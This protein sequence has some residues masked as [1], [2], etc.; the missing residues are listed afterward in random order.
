MNEPQPFPAPSGLAP[1]QGLSIASLILGILSYVFCLFFITGIPA[2]ITG[3]IAHSRARKQPQLYGGAGLALAGLILGYLSLPFSLVGASLLLPALAKAKAR[4]QT[5]Q[6][7]GNMKMI[8]LGARLYSNDHN[9]RFPPDFL[10]M[11]NELVT[12]KIL[13]CPADSSKTRAADFSQFNPSQNLS[14]EFLTPSAKEAD[15]LN[16]VAF[17]CP[18]HGNVGMG[19]GSVQQRGGGNVRR[20]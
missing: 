1:K 7:V 4:A 11:S 12:P 15:V 9:D 18:I 13:V 16:Q 3:H 5:I 2:I 10:S 8:G 19:D 20:R 17:R 6:C 14:Y